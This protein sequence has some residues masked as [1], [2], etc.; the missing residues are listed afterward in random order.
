MEP[1]LV[2]KDFSVQYVSGEQRVYAVNHINLVVKANDTLG[3]VGESGSGKTTLAMALLRLL[4]EGSSETTGQAEF[5]GRDLTTMSQA[6]LRKLRWRELAVVFQKSMNSMSPVHRIRT[7]IEDIYRVHEPT[8]SAADIRKRALYLFRLVNLPERVYNAYPH[9]LSGGM[10][11]R[12]AIALSL[13]H[14]PALLILDEAT[15]ALDVVTQGQI[16]DEILAMEKEFSMTRIMITHDISVVAV[17][18]S[19]IAVMYAGDLVETGATDAV[20]HDPKHPYTKALLQSIPALEGEK[21]QLKGIPGF[22][23]DLSVRHQGCLFTDRCPEAMSIC[24]QESPQEYAIA[25]DWGVRC[26]LYGR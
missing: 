19:R 2:L 1:I 16:L 12:V 18:C 11:Q 14:D 22:L 7:Q 23:P 10:M 20:L 6:E 8:A 26:H 3:I 21:G 24:R 5:K 15:T 4:P 13:L 9:Q 25:D 17:S